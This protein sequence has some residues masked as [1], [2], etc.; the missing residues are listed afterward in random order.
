M[1]HQKRKSIHGNKGE[2]E[3]GRGPKNV[4][5]HEPINVDQGDKERKGRIPEF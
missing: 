3:K 1:R 2:H 5:P 4:R